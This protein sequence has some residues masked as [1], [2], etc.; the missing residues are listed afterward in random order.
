MS[1]EASSAET[2]LNSVVNNAVSE[3]QN[4]ENRMIPQE[5]DDDRIPV[6]TKYGEDENPPKQ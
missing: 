5:K 1:S 2:T 4:G 3:Y 6:N